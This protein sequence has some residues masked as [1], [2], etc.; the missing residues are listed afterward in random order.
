VKVFIEA[1]SGLSL[2]SMQ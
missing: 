2:S 1:T